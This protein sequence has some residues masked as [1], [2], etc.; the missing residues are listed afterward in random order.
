MKKFYL[1]TKTLL[2]AALLMIGANAWAADALT[3]DL[4]VT[5]YKS[6]NLFDFQNKNYDGTALANFEALNDLG[7]TAQCTIGTDYGKNNWYD[8]TAK[9]HGLRLQS[10]GGRWIQF[11]V[12]I[13][14][15]DYIIIN[16]GAASEAY[17]ISMTDGESV[18]VAEASDYLC[19]KATKDA[20]NLKLTVHRYN[21]LL[22]IL[23]MTKDESAETADYT[24]NYLLNGEGEPVKVSSGNTAVGST[25]PT[26]VSFFS[27]DVKYFRADG[28]PESFEI[29]KSG[30]VFNVNVRQAATYNYSLVSNLGATLVAG[31]GFEDESL[32]V[33]YPRYQLVGSKLYEAPVDNKE[34]RKTVVLSADDVSVTVDYAEKEGV[35]ACFYIEGEAVEG[36]TETT[37]GNITVRASQAKAGAAAEDVAITTLPAGKYVL[38]AGIFASKTGIEDKVVN[39]GIGDEIFSAAFSAVN[40]NE[41]ASKE[42]T[43]SEAAEVKYIAEGTWGDA[44]FDYI[45]IEKLTESVSAT[46]S[47]AGYAT[48]SS[49]YPVEI[50]SGVEAYAAKLEGDKVTLTQVDEVPANT[51]VILKAAAGVYDLPVVA[52]AAAIAN[53][54]LQISN[55]SVTGDE[56]TIYVLGDGKN[57][58]GFYWLKSGNTLEA[59]KAY[60]QKAGSARGFI[61]FDGATGVNEVNVNKAAVKTGKIYNLNG[62]IVSKPS[63]GLFIVDGKVVSF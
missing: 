23:I 13:K 53:N 5:G 59:G 10:G 3:K 55:G 15:D 45:W 35:D 63:K 26:E 39:F 27:N 44:Q 40:L 61:G 43:L 47:A 48:F 37:A 18:S 21:F 25:V 52:S 14:K 49:A 34:Y 50:P 24:I 28:Q 57:G 56:S 19:L 22:Q 46:I 20:E 7:V 58:V 8:D 16:G 2:V 30:N 32:R 29:A 38:H 9:G 42:Y 51:G 4:K 12:D 41:V 17:E 1:L 60:L 31:S 62:Q 54:D 6:V 33:G 11:T 36:M